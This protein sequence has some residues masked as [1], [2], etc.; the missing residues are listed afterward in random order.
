MLN[1]PIGGLDLGCRAVGLLH[2]VDPVNVPADGQHAADPHCL[3]T[4]DVCDCEEGA[5]S[6]TLICAGLEV[7]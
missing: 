1:T 4:F 3:T 7:T 5:T 2:I 6:L